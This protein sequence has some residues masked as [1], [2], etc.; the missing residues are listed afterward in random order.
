R[1]DQ[2]I[3]QEVRPYTRVWNDAKGTSRPVRELAAALVEKAPFFVEPAIEMVE[4]KPGEKLELTL[5][6]KRLWPDFDGEIKLLPLAFAGGFAMPEWTV[7]A[8]ASEAKATI[9]A[10]NQPGDFTLALLSQAQV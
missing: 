7:P 8:G 6:V 10:G 1:G 2:T 3:K 4:V 5:R 9:T